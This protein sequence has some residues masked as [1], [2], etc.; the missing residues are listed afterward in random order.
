MFEGHGIQVG[1]PAKYQHWPLAVG[2]NAFRD[3]RLWQRVSQN[4]HQRKK[5][6]R[7]AEPAGGCWQPRSGQACLGFAGSA[8]LSVWADAGK[9]PTAQGSEVWALFCG[10]RDDRGRRP[11][12]PYRRCP[13]G[14]QTLEGSVGSCRGASWSRASDP[15]GLRGGLAA[16]PANRTPR[17]THLRSGLRYFAAMGRHERKALKGFCCWTR[18]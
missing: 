11:E 14:V 2:I 4:P 15:S 12:H 13:T 8:W 3:D 5:P 17:P 16:F 1:I 18:T 6:F 9:W 10:S 7:R